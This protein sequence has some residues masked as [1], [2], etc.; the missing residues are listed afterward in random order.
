MVR[1]SFKLENVFGVSKDAVLSYVEREKVDGLF[2]E[3]LK[4]DRQIIVY[5]ASKQGKTS[6]VG[7][8]LP[9]DE[10][11]VV[12]LTPKYTLLDIYK[13]ILRTAGLKIETVVQNT[14]GNES[15]NSIGAKIKA[16]FPFFSSEVGANT[17]GTTRSSES[18]SSKFIELNLHLPN[19]IAEGLKHSHNK[20]HIILEN[21]HYLSEE[22]QQEF[23]YDLR[24]FQE[25]G[26]RFI[27][28]GVWREKNRLI[29]FNGDLLDRLFEIPVEP[30]EKSDFKKVAALGA[31]KLNI[32]F[33]PTLLDTLFDD[34]FDSIGVVQ[35]LLKGICEKSNISKTSDS[36]VS[37][38]SLELLNEAKAEKV[39]SY[40]ARHL[41]ALEAIA[42]GRKTTNNPKSDDPKQ[43][44]LYLPYYT[45]KSFLEFDFNDVVEG[46]KRNKLELKIKSSHHR[47]E[48]VRAGDMS[49]LLYN[50]AKLQSEKNIS[51]PIFDYDK[52]TQTLRVIDSTFYFFLRNCNRSDILSSIPNPLQRNV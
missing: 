30:W 11:I 47:S 3:G 13:T 1:P 19:D 20:K 43:M 46:I 50:F 9:Y 26:V 32:A 44:P 48:D 51:P 23:A 25:L 42:E 27:I 14:F 17:Q 24:S 5:G 37:I 36:E 8:H 4:T 29:Q 39:Q 12:S 38:F 35:E 31:G 22:V 33:D 28:L 52:T 2:I 34:A 15:Q 45:V 41:R 21:F 10:N 40:Q 16:T 6:L 49:N 7:K 18:T